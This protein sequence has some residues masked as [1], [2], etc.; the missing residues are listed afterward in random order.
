[1]KRIDVHTHIMP[2][3]LPD[4]KKKFGYG[5][6]IQLI[7]KNSCNAT[8]IRDDGTFFRDITAN[9]WDANVRIAESSKFDVAMQVLSTIPVFFTYWAKPHDAWEVAKYLNDDIAR[10]VN[11]R[12]L[13]FQGLGTVPLQNTDLAIKELERC[14][15]IGLRGVEIGTNVD[16]RNL[17]HPD[18]FP[19]FEACEKL[20]ASVF[21]HPWDMLGKERMQDYWLAWLVGMP[22]ETSLAICHLIFSGVFHK[23]P[24]LRIAFA[25]GGGA[26]PGTIG[27]IER[28]FITR[29]DLVAKD[30]TFNPRDYLG[31]FFLDSLVH[32]KDMLR[33]LISL[34]GED[35]V[36]LG[37]D[38]P[39]PLGEDA[40]GTL[41]GSLDVGREVKEKLY[42]KNALKWLGLKPDFLETP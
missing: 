20:G 22:T 27:R 26:F 8:M 38:Y 35:K 36:M 18:L 31:H 30:N 42:T 6:F 32:D 3:E 23:L 19:F 11:E 4:F 14:M 25:H 12:P 9:S 7:Q 28:G 15:R 40:P 24:K 29:P 39:F 13:Q 17:G 5:G 33:Y 34:V 21:V 41:I 2:K 1:M 37:S 16:G 10:I